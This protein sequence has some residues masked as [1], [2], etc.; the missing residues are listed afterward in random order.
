MK[1]QVLYWAAQDIGLERMAL[2]FGTC[3]LHL[4][5]SS[6][7]AL[8]APCELAINPFLSALRPALASSNNPQAFALMSCAQHD[9]ASC[10]TARHSPY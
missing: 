5:T 8:T 4:S 1:S 7:A 10:L 6:L 3:Q 9:N 2:G